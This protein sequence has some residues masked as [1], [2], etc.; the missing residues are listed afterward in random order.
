MSSNVVGAYE[1][2]SF[3]LTAVVSFL[4]DFV[5]RLSLTSVKAEQEEE[6]ICESFPPESPDSTDEHSPS[7]GVDHGE[8]DHSEEAG[9]PGK[10]RLQLD[11]VPSL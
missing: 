10:Q 11:H 3:H 8:E 6:E 2:Y 1:R 9:S 4:S 7:P 5:I